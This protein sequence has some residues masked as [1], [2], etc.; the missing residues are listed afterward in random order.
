MLSKFE[1]C[2]KNG[3]LFKFSPSLATNFILDAYRGKNQP[4]TQSV[5]ALAFKRLTRN[6]VVNLVV[7]GF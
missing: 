6:T 2:T 4:Y 7:W 1:F 3:I 5:N